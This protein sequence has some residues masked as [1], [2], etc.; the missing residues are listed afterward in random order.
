MQVLSIVREQ[1]D[2][3]RQGRSTG[4]QGDFGCKSLMDNGIARF[5]RE[6]I[7]KDEPFNLLDQGVLLGRASLT[8]GAQETQ[9]ITGNPQTCVFR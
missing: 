1:V 5:D 8:Q 9:G 4:Q 3:I 7:W 6:G 2:A